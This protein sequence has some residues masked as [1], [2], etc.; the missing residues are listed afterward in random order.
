MINR[1][2]KYL[3]GCLVIVHGFLQ[4][5]LRHIPSCFRLN[6][7]G[8]DKNKNQLRGIDY[9]IERYRKYM[10]MLIQ[11]KKELIKNMTDIDITLSNEEYLAQLI[12]DNEDEEEEDD[13]ID[14]DDN[15]LS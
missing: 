9:K 3:V 2:M 6:Y 13:E 1:I 15:E 7:N 5:P 4:P 12:G 10:M 11:E 14:V 8:N